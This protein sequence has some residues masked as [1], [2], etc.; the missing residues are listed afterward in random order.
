ME[1]LNCPHC[2]K[3]LTTVTTPDFSKWGGVE[4]DVCLND[5]CKYF[6]KSWSQ[7]SQQAG[8]RVGYRYFHGENG[9]EGPLVVGSIDTYKD[10]IISDEMKKARIER[11]YK[12]EQ[13]FRD[14]L[15]AIEQA[16]ENKDEQLSTWLGQLKKLKYPN[17]V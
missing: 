3:A 8:T 17:K 15:E 14:L 6:L 7:L 16:K 2:G 12:A 5:M 11:E 10:S 13:E 1:N 9:Q 4:L